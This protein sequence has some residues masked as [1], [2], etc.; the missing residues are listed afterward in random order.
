VIGGSDRQPTF[1]DESPGWQRSG[2]W[3]SIGVAVAFATTG[4]VLGLSAT[5]RAEDIDNLIAFR[6]AM[7]QP[8]EFSSTT[9]TRYEELIEE[10][11][12]LSTYS[13]LAFAAAGAA[14]A[15]AAV[16]FFLDAR[17]ESSASIVPVAGAHSLGVA[18]GWRF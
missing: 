15:T 12:R 8:L 2:A 6:D 3:V 1:A 14:T 7:G 17:A 11:E 18:A 5:S 9:R 4:A 10:G 16:L 13:Q